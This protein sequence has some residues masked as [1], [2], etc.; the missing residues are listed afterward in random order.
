MN[1][2][3]LHDNI[4]VKLNKSEEKS[5]GG[6]VFA[7]EEKT[8]TVRATV[9]AVGPGR[10]LE[11]GVR[12]RPEIEAGQVVI[13]P[14]NMQTEITIDGEKLNIVRESDILAVFGPSDT[15]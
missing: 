10:V 7:V 14:R 5:P 15:K 6:I 11:T 3:P 9:V 4:I 12:T 2:R 13:V 8:T 1:I